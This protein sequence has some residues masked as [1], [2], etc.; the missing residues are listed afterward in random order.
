M[1]TLSCTETD[2]ERTENNMECGKLTAKLRDMVTVRFFEG[3][4]EI[5]RYH[6][7]E[8]PDEIKA[9][10]FKGYEFCVP[11]SGTITFKIWLEENPTEWPEPRARKTRKSKAEKKAEAKEPKPQEAEPVE[12]QADTALSEIRYKGD[13][14]TLVAALETILD[15]RAKYENAPSF[16]YDLNGEYKVL[17]DGTLIGTISEE[18]RNKLAAMGFEQ[19]TEAE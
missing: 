19:E 2:A 7:I 3:D 1:V 10:P 18:L 15:I 17:R 6:N 8:L 12:A 11:A 4:N 9:L 13:R 5:K 16:A 14:K